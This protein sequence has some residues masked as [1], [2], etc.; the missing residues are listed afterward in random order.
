MTLE[1]HYVGRLQH[2]REEPGNA[3][4]GGIHSITEMTMEM[5]LKGAFTA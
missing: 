2:D 3:P 5:P 4:E 1:M